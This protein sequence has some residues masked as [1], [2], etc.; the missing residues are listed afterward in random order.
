MKAIVVGCGR[1]GSS[2]ARR[3]ARE[4]WDVTAVDETEAALA[5]L[6]EDWGGGFVVGHGMDLKTLKKAGIE[7]T[8]AVVIATDGDNTNIVVAQIAQQQFEVPRVVV[9]LLDPHRAEFYASRGLNVVCPTKTAIEQLM[10][11]VLAEPVS[12]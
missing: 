7:E 8:D 9:R 2:V 12:A 10:R 4:G 6:G 11:T 1:V 5:R 3:L